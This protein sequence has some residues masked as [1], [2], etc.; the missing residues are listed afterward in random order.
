MSQRSVVVGTCQPVKLL[1]WETA[2]V[3]NRNFTIPHLTSPRLRDL[4]EF[5]RARQTRD[6]ASKLLVEDC[7][8]F[9]HILLSPFL[10]FSLVP[11]SPPHTHLRG[12][13]AQ[14]RCYVAT[15]CLYGMNIYI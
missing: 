6:M 11:Q 7:N 9:H 14:L 10:L 4:M 2:T 13:G 8:G 5:C 15:G 12:G 1:V 3:L